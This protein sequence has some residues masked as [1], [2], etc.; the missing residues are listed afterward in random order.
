M[1]NQDE[2]GWDLG[3]N[4]AAGCGG[5]GLLGRSIGFS[6]CIA[7]ARSSYGSSIMKKRDLFYRKDGLAIN[8]SPC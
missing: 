3:G 1:V 8:D 6:S 4:R 7:L 2:W 5:Y